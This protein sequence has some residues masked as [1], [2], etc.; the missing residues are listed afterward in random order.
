MNRLQAI[1]EKH[2]QDIQ[3]DWL[4]ELATA[5]RRSD[6]MTDREIQEQSSEL[7]AGILEGVKSGDLQNLDGRA[8]GRAREIMQAI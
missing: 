2:Q 1:I 3:A 7:L 5:T 4:R 6:L 8:W